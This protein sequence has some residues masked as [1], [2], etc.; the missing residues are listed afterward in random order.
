MT[1]AFRLETHSVLCWC[2]AQ[3]G[4]TPT[5]NTYSER[6]KGAPVG[7]AYSLACCKD[8]GAKFQGLPQHCVLVIACTIWLRFEFWGLYSVCFVQRVSFVCSRPEAVFW[9]QDCFF[10]SR[11]NIWAREPF[12]CKAWS[13]NKTN[14]F[15]KELFSHGSSRESPRPKLILSSIRPIL[16]RYFAPNPPYWII[17]KGSPIFM[18][19]GERP[20]RPRLCI[21][22][23]PLWIPYSLGTVA[24]LTAIG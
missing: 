18:K 5:V 4:L 21:P 16:V 15:A 19:T 22:Y 24:G 3:N 6:L 7:S 12:W 1:F 20:G 14:D 9:D 11:V 10:G 17:F 8:K 2:S 13:R 23:F